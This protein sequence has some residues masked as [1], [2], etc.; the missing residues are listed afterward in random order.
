MRTLYGIISVI[1]FTLYILSFFVDTT[2]DN[3]ALALLIFGVY[4]SILIEIKNLDKNK[5]I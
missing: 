2:T 5:N 4:Y 1:C 3:Q